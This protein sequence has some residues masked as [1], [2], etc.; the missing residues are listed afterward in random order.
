MLEKSARSHG[1]RRE[2]AAQPISLVQILF[3]LRFDA[4]RWVRPPILQIT[5]CKG[6]NTR[7]SSRNFQ[8][9]IDGFIGTI[10][11][12]WSDQ[13]VGAG[14][15][16]DLS[17]LRL[18]VGD[19]SYNKTNPASGRRASAFGHPYSRANDARDAGCV[20]APR[21]QQANVFRNPLAL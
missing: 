21:N 16:L 11:S 2:R 4:L 5:R 1:G 9:T 3:H 8:P 7:S 13:T 15:Q 10:R 12:D 18:S 6:A 17:G 20:V 19:G 14:Y